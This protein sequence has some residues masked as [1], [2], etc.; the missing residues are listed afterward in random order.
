MACPEPSPGPEGIPSHWKEEGGGILQ[1]KKSHWLGDPALLLPRTL[2]KMPAKFTNS[3]HL[4]LK[5]KWHKHV[6]WCV[7]SKRPWD[8]H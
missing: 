1:G 3:P 5:Q 8:S 2:P 6:T 7:R 4:F